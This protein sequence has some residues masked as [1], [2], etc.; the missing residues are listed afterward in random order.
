[1]RYDGTGN[2]KNDYPTMSDAE[3]MSMPVGLWAVDGA[4]LYLWCMNSNLVQAH[5]IAQA[6]GFDIKTVITWVKG[7]IERNQLISH[8]G[9]GHYWR[10]STEHVLFG[11][12]GKLATR[13]N[14]LPTAFIAPRGEHSE[15]PAAFYDM[16]ERMSPGPYLDVFARKQRFN[17]DTWGN[18]AFDF[19]THG[20]WNN[21][22][23]GSATPQ[24]ATPDA[25]ASLGVTASSLPD[26]TERRGE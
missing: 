1:M 20:L 12:R 7:R 4:H 22:A 24:V 18:E 6:W 15:K 2:G 23:D 25:E 3:L 9:L 17:W 5:K 14:D 8:I 13:N 26:A 21:S 10:N 19:R 16:V 11:V